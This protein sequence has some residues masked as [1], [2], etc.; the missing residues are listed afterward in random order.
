MLSF[1]PD[2]GLERSSDEEPFPELSIFEDKF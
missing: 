1:V 2:Y